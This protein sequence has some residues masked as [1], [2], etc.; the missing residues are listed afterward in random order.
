[1]SLSVQCSLS[2]HICLLKVG[3]EWYEKFVWEDTDV[4]GVVV[5]MDTDS[6]AI[7]LTLRNITHFFTSYI[8]IIFTV[9][10]SNKILPFTTSDAGV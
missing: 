10:W 7:L 8:I 9:R 4:Y 1:M 5:S 3:E 2:I 6:K